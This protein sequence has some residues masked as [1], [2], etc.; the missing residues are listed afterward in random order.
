MI[1]ELVVINSCIELLYWGQDTSTSSQVVHN[2]SNNQRLESVVN[3][4]CG[5]ITGSCIFWFF[6]VFFWGGADHLL[7]IWS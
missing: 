7:Q 2:T 6:L 1:N 3:L 4:F 5:F